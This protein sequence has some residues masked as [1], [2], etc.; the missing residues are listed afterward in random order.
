MIT[1]M[2]QARATQQSLEDGIMEISMKNGESVVVKDLLPGTQYE[3]SGGKRTAL[4]RFLCAPP[5][6][7]IEAKVE[8]SGLPEHLSGFRTAG[9]SITRL[10]H[11]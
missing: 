3:V 10:E 4:Y 2:R 5:T 9:Y 7:Q 8:K 1:W 11:F 6:G